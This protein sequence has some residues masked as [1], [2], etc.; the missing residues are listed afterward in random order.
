MHRFVQP[1]TPANLAVSC[2]ALIAIM[3][4]MIL[5]LRW[6]IRLDERGIWRRLLVRW[7]LWP[8][9]DF[10]TGAIHK[11]H[12]ISLIDRRRPLWR[13]RIR[14]D[15]MQRA[16]WTHVL[17]RVNQVYRLP[18]APDLPAALELHS[19]YRRVIRLGDGVQIT[20]RGLQRSYSWHDVVRL[21]IVRMDPLRRDF[22]VLQLFLPD[23]EI[24]LRYET[25]QGGSSP[26]WRG[27]DAEV[28]N[29]FLLAKLPRSIVDIE[30]FGERPSR[31]VDV[32]RLLAGVKVNPPYFRT[33]CG[34]LLALAAALI[35]VVAMN[36]GLWKA[37]GVTLL[38]GAYAGIFALVLQS[39]RKRRLELKKQ[40]ESWLAEFR[41]TGE[42][43]AS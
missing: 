4:A 22:Q 27:A 15:V 25:H 31:K 28:I 10:A 37:L 38:S 36:D 41:T 34:I 21:R 35:V 9:E 24:R 7:E 40:L 42:R 5:P 39:I 30:L 17:A 19:G 3:L 2:A 6:A 26:G 23:D 13:R 20:V 12:P 18:P 32:E 43:R 29:E 16:D 1:R 11:R 33:C 14:L 8:W